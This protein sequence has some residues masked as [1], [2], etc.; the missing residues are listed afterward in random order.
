M[1]G[2]TS[3]DDIGRFGAYVES[4]FNA[5]KENKGRSYIV[6]FEILKVKPTVEM[7][8]DFANV[9]VLFVLNSTSSGKCSL[10]EVREFSYMCHEQQRMYGIEE[11]P[12][13]IQ[14]FCTLRLWEL[15]SRGRKKIEKF[16]DWFMKLIKENVSC[17]ERERNASL[18][19]VNLGFE[20]GK[21]HA[22]IQV[23]R[24]GDVNTKAAINGAIARAVFF[25]TGG[26]T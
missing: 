11:L 23:Q 4:E 16:V 8:I 20:I 15:L 3:R 19:N 13:Q 5:I 14:A 6:L 9:A 7:P 25:G 12:T 24:L 2:G 17:I 22:V 21:I 26:Y 18:S 10:H 1:G